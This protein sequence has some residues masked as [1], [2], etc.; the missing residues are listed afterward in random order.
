[1]PIPHD[2]VIAAIATP[3]GE[4]A[5]S[6]I[7]VS[8]STAISLVDNIFRGRKPLEVVPTHTAHVGQIVDKTGNTIDQAVVIL[9]RGPKSYT[10]ENVVEI[11][12]HGGTFITRKILETVLN[13]GA[14]H[15]EP[16]EFTHRAFLNGRMDLSQAEAVADLI[17]ARSEAA[18]SASI[19]QLMGRLSAEVNQIRDKLLNLC[20]LVELGLDFSEEGIEFI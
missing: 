20:S 7:R 19:S 5:I 9:F 12:C 11:N 8:G 15:A 17:K 18:H 14:R 16:G 13:C 1:M 2:D 4:G 6:V 3:I 10:G